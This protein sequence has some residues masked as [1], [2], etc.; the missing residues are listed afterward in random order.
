MIKKNDLY[1]LTIES[2]SNEGNGIGH[3]EG[4]VVF[5][6]YTAVGD[7]VK[8]KIIK[9]KKDYLYA[10]VEGIIVASKTRIKTDCPSYGQCGG[11][12]FR[13]ITYEEELRLKQE[14]VTS[15]LKRIGNIVCEVK[16]IVASPY[17]NHYRNKVQ[18]PVFNNDDSLSTGF[19]AKRSHRVVP[20]M[21]YC[22][23][24][25]QSIHEIAYY[26]CQLL[27]QFGID[28][29]NEIDRSGL[30]RHIV[31]RQSSQD[32]RIMLI[33]VLNGK[34]FKHEDIF[35][36]KLTEEYKSIESIIINENSKNTNV[37]LGSNFRTIYGSGYLRDSI[38]GIKLRISPNSFLQI[39]HDVCEKLYE[40]I[41]EY[42]NADKETILLDL[43]C[44]IGSI[45]LALA[46]DV[47][48]VIGVEINAMAIED[49]RYNASLNG[50]TNV[51][52]ICQDAKEATEGL[53]VE[54]TKIDVVVV[55]PPRKGCDQNTL[56]SIVTIAP[57]RIIMVSC[58]P[59]TLARD[60]SILRESGYQIEEVSILDM[61]P[62]T[63]H[64]ESVALLIKR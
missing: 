42:I 18:L 63:V 15:V 41:R 62:R 21:D 26:C 47:K 50:I 32:D 58:N 8:V 17:D 52:F 31:I 59:A 9:I 61:F 25:P 57:N 51:S 54:N 13:H 16:P 53:I 45:G 24:D 22:L 40:K 49:A 12:N 2:V 37:I 48:E 5:V 20:F 34:G 44:G 55:D 29:Y 1:T 3:L 36:D 19:F 46:R 10:R 6:P 64:T 56:K 43:F 35:C 7:I 28:S 14:Y 4:M 60:V 27:S 38:S 33:L 39:N 30:L 23:I 11:C